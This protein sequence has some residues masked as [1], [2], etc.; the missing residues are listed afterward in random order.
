MAVVF[1][2]KLGSEFSFVERI[3]QAAAREGRTTARIATVAFASLA[4]AV[5]TVYILLYAISYV[6]RSHL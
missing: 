1:S 6:D 2:N 5:A 3:Q 4:I